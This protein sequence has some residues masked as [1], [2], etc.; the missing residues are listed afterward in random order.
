MELFID[1]TLTIFSQGSYSEQGDIVILAAYLGQIP[2][3]RDSLAGVVTTVIDE[4]DATNLAERGDES[5]IPEATTTVERV[6]VS[7]RVLIR[8]VDS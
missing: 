7:K 5:V 3:I 1:A 2:R 8:L 4:R 6:Q